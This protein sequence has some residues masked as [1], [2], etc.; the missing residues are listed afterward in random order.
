M[1]NLSRI[2][3]AILC[4]LLIAPVLIGCKK[5][6]NQ[7]GSGSKGLLLISSIKVD[8]NS[9]TDTV[10]RYDYEYDSSNRLTKVYYSSTGV[11]KYLALNL[12]YNST[13]DMT[14]YTLYSFSGSA[15]HGTL[16]FNNGLPLTETI[17]QDGVNASYIRHFQY[18]NN[19]NM[20]VISE[21]IDTAR[22]DTFMYQNNNLMY[23]GEKLGNYA[24][25][26]DTL[27]SYSTVNTNYTY[28]S[29]KG[30]YSALNIKYYFNDLIPFANA[31][32]IA[33]TVTKSDFGY[34]LNISN[35]TS[36]F[37]YNGEGYPIQENYYTPPATQ[38]LAVTYYDYKA[39]N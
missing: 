8:G 7:S 36:T 25:G 31:N 33:T 16:T 20:L 10:S 6:K 9:F 1:K 37:I 15:Q 35:G 21:N 2:L 29:K 22:R 30:P 14:N 38:L 32:E 27:V 23:Y 28:G 4:L 11:K 5:E 24:P 26:I 13:G 39:A 17:T 19:N 34:G 18:S 3:K 12:S